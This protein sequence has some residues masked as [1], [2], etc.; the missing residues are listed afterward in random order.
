MTHLDLVIRGG[1]VV[2]GSG[3]APFLADVAIANGKIAAIGPCIE[4]T[5]PELDARGLLVTPGFIDV[6]THYDGQATWDARLQPSSLQGVTTAVMGNC[7]VGFAPCRAEDR[8]TL[9][10]LMEG[11]EDIPGAALSEGLRWDWESFPQYLDSLARQSRDIDI[12]ALLPHGALRV[13]VMGQRAVRR[14]A[15]TAADLAA[16]CSLVGAALDAGAV[17]LSTSRTAA[18]RTL[19]GELTPMFDAEAAELRAL[20]LALAGRPN[21]VF[22]MI[23][24]FGDLEGEFE[25]LAGIC[26]DSGCHGTLTV[27]QVHHKP[28]QHEQL[29]ALIARA[30]AQGLR[31]TG[32]V[33]TR[34]VGV[35]MGFDT[36]LNP[37]SCRPAYTALAGLP[38]TER[39]AQLRRPEVRATILGQ[40][41]HQP[42]VFMHYYGQRF[43]FMFVLCEGAA[44]L[45]NYLPQA[46]DS[47]AE[48]AARAGCAPAEWLYKHMLGEDGAALIYLP[49][50][51]YRDRNAQAI[52]LQLK[53][54][55]TLPA[56]GD[57]GAHVGTICDGSAGT[58]LLTEWV[59]ERGV[60]SIQAAVQMLSQKPAELY[61]MPD[62]GRLAVG[63]RAD[64]N[65]IDLA[66]L[67]IERPYLVRDLPA[68][69]RRFL[70][71]ARGYRATLV[72]GELTYRDG[73]ATEALP[74]RLLRRAGSAAQAASAAV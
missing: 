67:A 39:V 3:A 44:G 45:P 55:N 38:L 40:D 60:F 35:L 74:G 73:A 22:Q 71:G 27:A 42:H 19:A 49:L 33:I 62:R 18:H 8:A 16:M 63:L 72:A 15:A 51:N 30:N 7:G 56:L 65:L 54:P 21:A 14:E 20:G 25:I 50:A 48:R 52:E 2:D 57:G 70:Q 59:R 46:T 11:V 24:D 10:E 43:D 13:H 4:S 47:V 64:I 9:I 36:T 68:G 5:A 28:Q 31:I 32:Q 1:T 53:H 37:F 66:A 23:S 26:R 17:G 41:D 34:P 69:G 58:F 6:H 61:G 29:L 12:A